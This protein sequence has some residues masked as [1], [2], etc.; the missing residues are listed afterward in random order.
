[1]AVVTKTLKASG[2]DYSLMSTWESTE[3]T[4]LVTDGDTHVL[5]CYNFVCEESSAVDI[6]SWTTNSSNF[7]TIK[8]ATG[9][10]PDGSMTTGFELKYF[11][12][13]DFVL[14]CSQNYTVIENI[15]LNNTANS[16]TSAQFL[17]VSNEQTIKNCVLKGGSS[18]AGISALNSGTLKVYNCLLY[19]T[20]TG[21][22]YMFNGGAS[23]PR[24]V[25]NCTSIGGSAGIRS[26]NTSTDIRNCVAVG[27]G[28][29]DFLVS[30]TSA[31]TTNNASSDT[32]APGTSPQTGVTSTDFVDYAGGD[33]TP[34]SGSTKLAGTGVSLSGTFEDD[35]TGTAR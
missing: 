30:A 17:T 20:G 5:E 21:A 4:D 6:A 18:S 13:F 7:I 31:N 35:I 3:Q 12:S 34:T 24:I 10:G 32:T 16:G 9:E 33:Y 14:K 8:S 26:A 19:S 11:A 28:S 1:M 23:Y 22:A 25:Y 29:N 15:R 2:G 27:A